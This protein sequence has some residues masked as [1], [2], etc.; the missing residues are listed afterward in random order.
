MPS[1][2]GEALVGRLTD[3]FEKETFG[4]TWMVGN[5]SATHYPKEDYEFTIV[6]FC[7]DICVVSNALLIRANFPNST[8][9]VLR[10]CTAGV[11]PE[12]HEAALKTMEMCQIEVV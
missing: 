7:T 3:R 2:L 9:K 5:L 6:G 10:D 12:S 11:T 8:I 4:S 1:E